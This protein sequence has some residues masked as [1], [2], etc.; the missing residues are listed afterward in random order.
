M[1]LI[2]CYSFEGRRR[3]HWQVQAERGCWLKAL[4]L[5][6][7]DSLLLSPCLYRN[8][9]RR[10]LLVQVLLRRFLSVRALLVIMS[11]QKRPSYPPWRFHNQFYWLVQLS[12]LPFLTF[13]EINTLF[14]R[15]PLLLYGS[16]CQLQL[17][18]LSLFKI[19]LF[20]RVSKTYLYEHCLWLLIFILVSILVY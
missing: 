20:R 14:R 9:Q 16:A 19:P 6:S 15:F 12:Y 2:T 18:C 1:S 17:S 5:V 3:R 13:S 11:R 7:P 4:Q 8:H 10:H